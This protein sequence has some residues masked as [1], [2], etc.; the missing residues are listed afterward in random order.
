MTALSIFVLNYFD[1][2]Y[3]KICASLTGASIALDF[4]WLI[5]Y[6]GSYWSLPLLS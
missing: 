2:T 4:V 1:S 5:M 6:A 3:L